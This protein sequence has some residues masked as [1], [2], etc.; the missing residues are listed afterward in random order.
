MALLDCTEFSNPSIIMSSVV[1]EIAAMYQNY[2]SRVGKELLALNEE[3][4]RS[5]KEILFLNSF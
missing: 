2:N 4:F 3:E 5:F 1:W